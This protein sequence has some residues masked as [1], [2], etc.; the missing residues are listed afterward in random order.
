MA[1]STISNLPA[2]APAQSTDL[3]PIAR[4]GSNYS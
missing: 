1:D 3:L 4:G 2:G